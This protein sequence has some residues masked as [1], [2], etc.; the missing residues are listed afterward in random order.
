MAQIAYATLRLVTPVAA[1]RPTLLVE[2]LQ[3]MVPTRP[4]SAVH[5]PL[6]SAPPLM[7]RMSGRTQAASLVFWQMVTS[8]IARS[9]AATAAIA[10]GTI[11]LASN[12]QPRWLVP[13]R[14]S[15][16]SAR[17]R[18]RSAAGTTP[19]TTAAKLFCALI[20]MVAGYVA[21][22]VL[23]VVPAADLARRRASPRHGSRC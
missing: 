19:R 15:R 2:V 10:K 7:V 11:R 23:G 1:A 20:G 12:A 13:G 21:A 18:A 8:P 14:R 17:S 9:E 5:K 22:V 4:A 6:A 16:G 3:P